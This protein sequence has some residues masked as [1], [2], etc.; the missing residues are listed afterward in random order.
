MNHMWKMLQLAGRTALPR[1]GISESVTQSDPNET[2]E[3]ENEIESKAEKPFP[4]GSEK[5]NKEAK[6]KAKDTMELEGEDDDGSLSSLSFYDD[7][8]K[9]YFAVRRGRYAK[10][11]VF[12]SWES[13]REHIVGYPD[14]EY[15]ATPTLEQA[16]KYTNGFG[17]FDN[18]MHE[19]QNDLQGNELKSS[20]PLP[21]T[22]SEPLPSQ[23]QVLSERQQK[24]TLAPPEVRRRKRKY[25]TRKLLLEYYECYDP[26]YK[27]KGKKPLTIPRFLKE[28]EMF[29][30]KFKVFA[31]HW[32]R[33]GL[34]MMCNEEKP[35][36]EAVYKYDSWVRDRKLEKLG[37]DPLSTID[38]RTNDNK[39]MNNEKAGKKRKRQR[40]VV[41]L[42]SNGSSNHKNDIKMAHSPDSNGKNKVDKTPDS[43][44]KN[45]QPS[46][47]RKKRSPANPAL[48]SK[49]TTKKAN[50]QKRKKA[51]NPG[52][53][54]IDASVLEDVTATKNPLHYNNASEE[55]E[56]DNDEQFNTM[57]EKLKAYHSQHGHCKVNRSQHPDLA[58][59]VHYTRRRI[60]GEA[61][62]NGARALTLREE[63]L[64][65]DLDFDPVYK[66][67]VTEFNKY[68]GMRVAKLF[69]VVMDGEDS[70]EASSSSSMKV[71]KQKGMSMIK[72]VPFFGTVGRISSVC[73][74]VRKFLLLSLVFWAVD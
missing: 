18:T 15:I 49:P 21:A 22:P 30:D 59:F 45:N 42:S 52:V 23:E 65:N 44:K 5:K 36:D 57:Y 50:A 35:L 1:I 54:P 13:A 31:K 3:N 60:Q 25:T 71:S 66:E 20:R 69:D 72:K 53:S 47:K 12:L 7:F 40:P 39:N 48:R 2:N 46:K 64:L 34:L 10:N 61:T 28:R 24:T 19:D 11:S 63:K 73:N 16:H 58:Y 68:L 51:N 17:E 38:Q 4:K 9:L 37:I 26:A 67:I 74:R 14:A 8:P 27:V 70:D 55:D 56:D 62:R 41:V 33:S 6:D 32:Q 43:N 29:K